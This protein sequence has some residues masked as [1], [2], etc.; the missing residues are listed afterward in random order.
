MRNL[1]KHIISITVILLTAVFS[2][3]ASTPPELFSPV[4]NNTL[5]LTYNVSDEVSHFVNEITCS[6]YSTQNKYLTE[7]A[8]ADAVAQGEHFF[9]W[10]GK[11]KNGILVTDGDYII[12]LKGYDQAG[13]YKIIAKPL[14]VDSVGPKITSATFSPKTMTM[15]TNK[16]SVTIKL[17][18]PAT[19]FI[20]MKNKDTGKE[21]VFLARSSSVHS[22]PLTVHATHTWNYDNKFMPA[23]KDGL[24]DVE[25]TAQDKAGNMSTPYKVSSIRVDRTPP[26]IYAQSA[27]PYALSNSGKNPYQTTISYQLSEA[28]DVESN[29]LTVHGSLLTTT[30]KVVEEKTEKVVKT[31]SRLSSLSGI[32]T[33]KWDASSPTIKAGAYKLKIIAEDKF[34]NYSTAT[35]TC[36]KDGIAPVIDFPAA[37]ATVSGTVAIRGTAIDP[38]WTNDKPFKKYSLFYAEGNSTVWKSDLVKALNEGIRPVQGGST[39]GYFYTAGLAN[40]T[41]TIQVIAEEEGG[42]SAASTRTVTVANDPNQKTVQPYIELSHLPSLISFKN[43]DSVKLPI[44]FQNSVKP[45]NVNIEVAKADGQVVYYKKF[46]NVAGAPSLG[47]PEY[48]AGK[49]LGYFIWKDVD[50]VWHINWSHDGKSHTFSGNVIAMGGKIEIKNE[51]LKIKNDGTIISWNTSS[52]GGFSFTVSTDTNQLMITPKIDEDPSSPQIYARNIYL[53]ITKYTSDYLPIMIDVK[54]NSLTNLAAMGSSSENGGY[55][56]SVSGADWDGRLETGA[57]ADSGTYTVRVI[58]EGIDGIGLATAEKQ[59][60]ITTPF[61]VTNI[62]TVNK[63]FSTLGAPDRVSVYYNI[64]KAANA[65]AYVYD[66]NHKLVCTLL[67]NE[68]VNGAISDQNKHSFSWKGN[69]PKADSST[70]VTSGNYYIKLF[71]SAKDGTTSHSESIT[72]INIKKTFTNAN[73]ASLD[74]IGEKAFLNGSAI[75][76]AI[77]ESPYYFEAKGLGLYHPP[78]NFQYQLTASGKQRFTV[79]PYIP[80]AALMHRGF[81]QVD[82]K[83]K[84]RIEGKYEEHWNDWDRIGN[85]HHSTYDFKRDLGEYNWS[86]REDGK[87]GVSL[88]N[89]FN[90]KGTGDSNSWFGPTTPGASESYWRHYKK[91]DIVFELFSQREVDQFKENIYFEKVIVPIYNNYQTRGFASLSE[92]EAYVEKFKTGV[93]ADNKNKNFPGDKGIFKAIYNINNSVKSGIN[94][95]YFGRSD[96]TP[97][98]FNIKDNI[99]ISFSELK[100]IPT[101]EVLALIEERTKPINSLIN[102]IKADD[103]AIGKINLPKL[104]PEQYL[105]FLIRQPTFYDFWKIKKGGLVPSPEI[106]V[107]VSATGSLRKQDFT[108]LSDHEKKLV[109]R[110]NRLIL[111]QTY[112]DLCPP[113]PTQKTIW[114]VTISQINNFNESNLSYDLNLTLEAP[115]KYSRLTNRFIPWYGFVNKNHPLTKDFNIHLTDINRGLA[116]PGKLFFDDPEATPD[117]PYEFTA[118]EITA[119]LQGKSWEDKSSYLNQLASDANLK[120]YKGSLAST[121]GWDSY[122]TDEVIEFMPITLPES[123]KLIKNS[124]LKYTAQ[125][126]LTLYSA[127]QSGQGQST[128]TFDWPNPDTA[129][130]NWEAKYGAGGTNYQQLIGKGKIDKPENAMKYN[131]YGSQSNPCFYEIDQAEVNRKKNEAKPDGTFSGKTIFYNSIG[132]SEWNSG[133]S[134]G[135]LLPVPDYVEELTY[136]VNDYFDDL[137]VELHGTGRNGF[138]YAEDTATPQQWTTDD[139]INLLATNGRIRSG[140]KLFNDTD[141]CGRHFINIASEYNWNNDYQTDSALKFSFLKQDKFARDGGVNISNPNLE[142]NNWEIAV[143][144]KAWIGNEDL[145]IGSVYSGTDHT[146]DYFE[147]KLDP[148][149]REKRYVEITG[150]VSGAYE[151]MY[152]DGSKWKSIIKENNKRTGTLAWWDVNR[153]NGIYSILLKTGSYIATQDINIGTPVKKGGDKIQNVFSAYRRAQLSF[154]PNSFP[155]DQLVTVTPVT[156]TEITVRNRPV[157]MSHG[158]I[159]EIKPSPHKFALEKR[160]TL[161]FIYTFDDL[162]AHGYWSGIGLPQG[163]GLNIHQ[164]TADGDLE[165]VDNNLQ[166]VEKDGNNDLIYVFSAPL[167]H[168]ST[169]GLLNGKFKLSAPVVKADRYITNKST[170]TI[171]GTAE[172]DSELEVFVSKEPKLLASGSAPIRKSTADSKGNFRFKAVKLI[173][174][175]MNYIFVVSNPKGDKTAKTSG[176]VDVEKDT[177]PPVVTAAA[178]LKAFSPNED[179]RWD[180]V[181]YSMNSNEKGKVELVIKDPSGKSLVSKSIKAEAGTGIQLAWGKNG[182]NLYRQLATGHWNLNST[183]YAA[184]KFAD[185]YYTYTI[186]AIDEAGNISNNISGQTII[187]TTPPTIS[188]LNSLPNPFTPNKDGIKDITKIS[189]KLTEPAYATVSIFRD[190]GSLFRKYSKPVETTGSWIWDGRGSHNEILSGKF[191]YQISAEDPVGNIGKSDIKTLTVDHIPSLLAYAYADPNPFSPA[192]GDSTKIK[193]Y[194]GRDNCRVQAF[195]AGPGNKAIKN[196]V[197]GEL[198]DKGEHTAE[199]SGDYLPGYSGVL[200]TKDT[201][202]VGDGMYEF[203]IIALDSDGGT[204]ANVSNTVLVD[205]S[206]PAIFCYPVSVDYTAKKAALKY[207]IPETAAVNVSVHD[208]DGN[209]VD[210][211]FSGQKSAGTYLLDYSPSSKTQQTYF[212]VTAE[213]RAKN[214]SEKNSELFALSAISSISLDHAVYPAAITPN[215]DGHTDSAKITYKLSGGVPEYKVSVKILNSANATVKTIADSE[216]QNAGTYIYYWSGEKD[217]NDPNDKFIKNDGEYH[218][219]ITVEDKVGDLVT[220]SNEILT[221]IT[222]PAVSISASPSIFSPNGDQVSDKT[223]FTYTINYPQQWITKDAEVKIDVTTASGEVVFTRNLKHSPGTYNY[224]WDG[225]N[226]SNNHVPS[227]QYYVYINA[228]DALG[229][230]ALPQNDI[231]TVYSSMFEVSNDHINP[232]LNKC[233]IS[234]DPYPAAAEEVK[235]D[236]EFSEPLSTY[237]LVSVKQKKGSSAYAKVIKQ[238]DYNY[239]ASYQVVSGYDGAAEVTV[240]FSDLG[241]NGNSFSAHFEVDTIA[242]TFSN[243]ASDP[244]FIKAGDSTTIQFKSSEQLPFNPE[245]AINGNQASYSTNTLNDYAYT[246][247]VQTTDTNGLATIN[248][249]G[250]DFAGNNN[251]YT[252]TNIAES[253]RIDTVNPT[254]APYQVSVNNNVISQP[255][256]FT[257]NLDTIE[258]TTSVFYTLSEPSYV[259]VSVHKV[260]DA[261]TSYTAADFTALNRV[262]TLVTNQWQSSNQNLNWDG[263]ITE[264]TTTYDTDNNGYADAGKY[265][266]IVYAYDQAGNITAKKYG[267]TVWVQ[268]SI[269][270][271]AGGE[272]WENENPSPY[273]FSPN[274]ANA[275]KLVFRIN[276]GSFPKTYQNPEWISAQSISGNIDWDDINIPGN[277]VGTYTAR[278]YDSGGTLIKTL[279]NGLKIKSAVIKSITWDGTDSTGA[280]VTD[281]RYRIEVE[282]KDFTGVPAKYNNPYERWVVVDNTPPALSN[283][284]I[285]NKYISPNS[286]QSTAIKDTTINYSVADNLSLITTETNNVDLA[287][288]AFNNPSNVITINSLTRAATSTLTALSQL[289]DGAATKGGSIYAG[290]ANGATYPDGTY[291]YRIT[292]Q[293]AA[294]NIATIQANDLVVDTM[295]PGGTLEINDNKEYATGTAVNLTITANDATSGTEQMR[296][297]NNADAEPTTWE[298][299]ASSKTWTLKNDPGEQVINIKF[300]DKAGNTNTTSV[301]DSIFLDTG[302]PTGTISIDSENDYTKDNIV[303]LSLSATDPIPNPSGISKMRIWDDNAISE[304]TSEEDYKT[305]RDWTLNG[306]GQGARTVYIKYKDNAGN[307]SSICSDTITYDSIPPTG[308]ITIDSD[309]AYTNTTAVTLG[310]SATD[311]TTNVT[312]MKI[313]NGAQSEPPNSTAIAYA[314]SYSW[315]LTDAQDTRTVHVKYK[316][317]A[318]NWSNGYSDTIFFDSVAP[319]ITAPANTT[320][321]PYLAGTTLNFSVSDP[322][323]NSG[324]N[325]V[326]AKIKYGTA[327]IKDLAVTGNYSVTW[328]GTN[329][330][331]DYVNEGDYTLEITAQDNAGNSKISVSA[332]ITLADDQYIAIGTDP[333]ISIGGNLF[334]RWINGTTEESKSVQVYG[335]GIEGGQDSK[336]IFVE[337]NNCSVQLTAAHDGGSHSHGLYYANFENDSSG[338]QI[339]WWED[340]TSHLVTL[341]RGWYRIYAG[342]SCGWPSSCWATTTAKYKNIWYQEYQKEVIF[343]YED[344]IENTPT[345]GPKST[346]II[347]SGPVKATNDQITFHE[348]WSNA[349]NIYYKR[350]SSKDIKIASGVDYGCQGPAI[351]VDAQNN[352]YVAW[353]VPFGLSSKIYFQK[354]PNKFTP[355]NGTITAQ[356]ITKIKS[357]IGKQATLPELIAPIDGET[358]RTLRPIFKWTGLIGTTDYQIKLGTPSLLATPDRTLS[359]S[360]TINEANPSDGSRPTLS[361][362]IHEFDEGLTRGNWEWQVVANPGA[363]NEAASATEDFTID[364][365]LTITSVT[366][367]P[368]PFNPNNERTRIRYRLGADADEVIIRIYDITGSLVTEIDGDC[369]A[370]GSGI[371]DKY[372]D[373]EWNGRNGMGDVVLNGIYPFEIVAR[374]GSTSVSTRGKIAVLK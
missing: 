227:K 44:T 18:E 160:P 326:T 366:N 2:A 137:D 350:G 329:N 234:S 290:Q 89:K 56:P 100:S 146:K 335:G 47:K 196:L 130:A 359:K 345:S 296:I 327:T 121:I 320:F 91:V 351:A 17:N 348:V 166:S 316:D 354:V 299:F 249:N 232:T 7:I 257:P 153:L 50:D 143:Y 123:G 308:S 282:V 60:K 65:S 149:A 262:N 1:A 224:T 191:T 203:K 239:S 363:T 68:P 184:E 342:S 304:P 57:F 194:L 339:L 215:S 38:D 15:A 217:S 311:S 210:N 106:K 310:L 133:L 94:P 319:N 163:L 24:Y 109:I 179:G 256:P 84:A 5:T 168:F 343:E 25:I 54:N 79:Y 247:T 314:S 142:I 280:L 120:G 242:P 77:G 206:P 305:T 220:V 96:F 205:N 199:W 273:I 42:Q 368:N 219:E 229:T 276:R 245:V 73:Y 122:L 269:L 104:R 315:T 75:Q 19:V 117:E 22:S 116:F 336:W 155:Q 367:Y 159:V 268:D 74:P 55:N 131:G 248:I 189:Y 223:V 29:Q 119:Q 176:Y 291:T 274:V 286:S 187:D 33:L 167:N 161:R 39:L 193:Y 188:E 222:K 170:V 303:S 72:G 36:V 86:F 278:V 192:R 264:N 21:E 209:T 156:M 259:T 59:I 141:F 361:Y 214:S 352:A 258:D 46:P 182:F 111:E 355:I 37:A 186:F 208:I 270:L 12:K 148:Y 174:E 338:A 295:N 110:L 118:A 287:I 66:Y 297:W 9:N 20:R 254:V 292:A 108:A 279:S 302:I 82:V 207:S 98:Q 34:G 3:T 173:R 365:P 80:F 181:T 267:G 346:A 266:F 358:V 76:L 237:P 126:D 333:G 113:A 255:S 87:S 216:T 52:P 64:S 32:N 51:K 349:G 151:L 128:F 213:D 246:Y 347:S 10:D 61:E 340:D 195:V 334:L 158:P 63:T 103:Y 45:A 341:N 198:Q 49:D 162:L 294:G 325:S 129:L 105:N 27:V 228:T 175:G 357:P 353:F 288:E 323:P 31:Y 261:Q 69:Y 275:T 144:D 233:T 78:R 88:G 360:V 284:S 58:A 285:N 53:G 218:Y 197:F 180:A 241:L 13:N 263:K 306:A 183:T 185:G 362:S 211:V 293:D 132:K 4:D 136:S 331:N 231:L 240:N 225:K 252:T 48:T 43:D 271:I 147:L 204:P 272:Q 364:P 150:S 177:T 6:L 201:N 157:I 62:E 107:L 243:V 235:I 374:T 114:I 212:K 322:T 93:I 238:D 344:N 277:E 236:L 99:G 321:N 139:D 281:G 312:A 97:E 178:N 202:K 152:F 135:E 154:L 317:A 250:E 30:I 67:E 125:T 28:N 309:N 16:Q 371:F 289:W 134:P 26:V 356:K 171:Y 265:A 244:L 11:Y 301:N 102:A 300:K 226:N 283:L 40:G 165:I 330:S 318:G 71:L 373:V 124:D 169:Y 112:P 115:I 230:P 324:I 190:E 35:A 251:N 85:T 372:N 328:D 140:S 101:E 370:E 145:N 253:F 200:S 369:A 23:L 307:W 172:P 298:N 164:I 70:I 221:V 313:W 127:A 92:A 41:Y 337:N 260:P 138:V 81:K 83:I 332:T 90:F 8:T 95:I 14:K